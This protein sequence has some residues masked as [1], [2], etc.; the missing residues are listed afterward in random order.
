MDKK[1]GKD[2]EIGL[3]YIIKE[4]LSQIIYLLGII[5]IEIWLRPLLENRADARIPLAILTFGELTFFIKI[6]RNFL[7]VADDLIKWIFAGSYSYQ[8]L[9]KFANRYKRPKDGARDG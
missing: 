7:S 9:K 2:F 5:V 3:Y 8:E 1:D 6:F 4:V